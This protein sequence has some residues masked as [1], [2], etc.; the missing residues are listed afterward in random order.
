MK[1][2]VLA[3][4]RSVPT[5]ARKIVGAVV[6][7][8]IL[9]AAITTRADVPRLPGIWLSKEPGRKM[10]EPHERQL[11][12]DLRRITG[13]PALKFDQD[14]R[15]LLGDVSVVKGGA[16]VARQILLCALG[17][18]GAFVIEDH[19]GSTSVTFGQIDEG[20]RYEDLRVPCSLLIWR[21]RLDFEDFRVMAASPEVRKS[22]NAGFTMLHE[23]L[24]GLGYRDAEDPEEIGD[25]ERLVNQAR[26]ELKLPI[27]D[28][29]F[30][31]QLQ[32][33]PKA[34]TLRLRFRDPEPKTL[35]T[36][37]PRRL[38]Y[39]FFMATTNLKP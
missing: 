23:L 22:F 28:Q 35:P 5:E 30:A 29:Y 37:Q 21:V 19:C 39:I 31:D 9:L 7:L 12:Q 8:M 25:C 18:G 32:I 17:S 2:A 4:G 38:H 20:M 36:K 15:L 11:V 26:A 27:R 10:P 13:L 3:E 14:G 34:Y 16:G 6:G 1:N 24:H 33:T